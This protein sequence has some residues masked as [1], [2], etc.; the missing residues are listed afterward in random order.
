M[1]IDSRISALRRGGARVADIAAELGIEPWQV[2]KALQRTGLNAELAT[3]HHP[4]R[5][6]WSDED[7]ARLRALYDAREDSLTSI[8]DT[9]GITRR[10]LTSRIQALGLAGPTRRV[11]H[12]AFA[13][14]KTGCGHPRCVAARAEHDALGI[15][16]RVAGMNGFIRDGCR[17]SVCTVAYESDKASRQTRTAAS[18]TRTRRPWTPDEDAILA[19]PTRLAEDI[20]RELGRTYSAVLAR[21]S[22]LRRQA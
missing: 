14:W 10:R 7:D 16:H 5:A 12:G 15:R 9:L 3:I 17:C 4:T 20:A 8:A 21:R 18:A 2:A 6:H 22:R 11:L 13:C 1:S 19:D